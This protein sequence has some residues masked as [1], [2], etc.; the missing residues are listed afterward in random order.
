MRRSEAER[1]DEERFLRPELQLGMTAGQ[2]ERWGV[3]SGEKRFGINTENAE[4]AEGT[5]KR[6]EA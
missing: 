2:A 5:E 3:V 4:D 6:A 1:K